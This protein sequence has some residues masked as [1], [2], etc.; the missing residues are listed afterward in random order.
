[1]SGLEI[2]LICTEIDHMLTNG[3]QRERERQIESSIYG[4]RE[5][6]RDRQAG[7]ERDINRQT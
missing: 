7:T 6:E 3:Q 2:R 1:M 5:R 4:H